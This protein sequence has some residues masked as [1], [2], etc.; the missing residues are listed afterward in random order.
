MKVHFMGAYEKADDMIFPVKPLC[1]AAG[2]SFI[3]FLKT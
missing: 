2:I 3:K 1:I